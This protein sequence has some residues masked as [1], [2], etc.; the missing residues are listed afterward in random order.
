MPIALPF[1]NTQRSRIRSDRGARRHPQQFKQAPYE[2][3]QHY[4]AYIQAICRFGRLPV[5]GLRGRAA[6]R[7]CDEHACARPIRRPTATPSKKSWC[8]VSRWKT[9]SARCSEKSARCWDSRCRS[10][11][12]PGRSRRSTPRRSATNRSST[13]PTSSRSSRAPT[14]IISSAGPT[15]LSCAVSRRRFSRTACC[16]RRAPTGNR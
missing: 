3:S 4:D 9:R 14:P 6:R 15:F 5:P 2:R 7:R 16:G 1:L 11:T 12:L 13:S 8:A 10:S